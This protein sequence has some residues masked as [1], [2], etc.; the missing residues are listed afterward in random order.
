MKYHAL[1]GHLS[2]LRAF[3]PRPFSSTGCQ[4]FFHREALL[5]GKSSSSLLLLFLFLGCFIRQKQR[6]GCVLND[7]NIELTL[8]SCNTFKK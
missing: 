3:I 6:L 5:F 2:T 1:M 8:N 7:A 4:L